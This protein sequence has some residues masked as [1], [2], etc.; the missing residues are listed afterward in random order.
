MA[1]D[2][3]RY[4]GLSPQ[5]IYQQP[6]FVNGLPQGWD[7]NAWQQT[8][9]PASTWG[10]NAGNINS[11]NNQGQAIDWSAWGGADPWTLPNMGA[12]A[13]PGNMPVVPPPAGSPTSVGN[14]TRRTRGYVNTV[15]PPPA[16]PPPTEEPGV[17]PPPPQGDGGSYVT[18]DKS[19]GGTPDQS[20][21]SPAANGSNLTIADGY[22]RP[23]T[24]PVLPQ[25]IFGNAPRRTGTGR[26]GVVDA[27][28]GRKS[29][30]TSYS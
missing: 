13:G 8:V 16:P 19:V 4:A 23:V 9:N 11:L 18:L 6:E 22:S 24:N 15:P 28:M 3:A 20:T 7:W 5:Q 2:Y 14:A 10:A 26:S 12:P 21:F 1:I 25:P 17:T 27:M 29:R 30:W